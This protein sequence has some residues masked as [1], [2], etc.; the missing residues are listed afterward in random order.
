ME[1]AARAKA[2]RDFLA[3]V[4]MSLLVWE[5]DPE[6]RGGCEHVLTWVKRCRDDLAF[7]SGVA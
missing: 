3:Q 6:V 4:R 1:D 2:W 7:A 5:I